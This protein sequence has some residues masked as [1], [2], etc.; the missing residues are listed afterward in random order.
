MIRVRILSGLLILAL[1]F[2]FADASPAQAAYTMTDL[3]TLGGLSSEPV[4]INEAGQV[5]GYSYLAGDDTQHGFFWDGGVM[6]DLG[7]TLV[8]GAIS[9]TASSA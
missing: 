4:A 5:I 2:S 6:T 9:P 7:T 1:I 3:G 8:G